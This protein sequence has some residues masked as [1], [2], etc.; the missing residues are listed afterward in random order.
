M[1]SLVKLVHRVCDKCNII[2]TRGEWVDRRRCYLL[3]RAAVDYCRGD[4]EEVVRSGEGALRSY[5]SH[6][7]GSWSRS[8]VTP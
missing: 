8:P 5:T 4:V 6:L 2:E 7:H 1:Y 3:S